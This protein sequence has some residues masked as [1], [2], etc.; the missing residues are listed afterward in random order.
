MKRGDFTMQTQ[1]ILNTTK[2]SFAMEGM[3]ATKDDEKNILDVLMGNRTLE[4]VIDEIKQKY[5]KNEA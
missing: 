2:G 4:E 5:T 3:H 1:A